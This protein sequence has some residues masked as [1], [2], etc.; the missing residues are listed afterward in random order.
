MMTMQ[1]AC[2]LPIPE[3]YQQTPNIYRLA[4][5][6]NSTGNAAKIM[7]TLAIAASTSAEKGGGKE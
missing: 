3:E 5:I 7:R 6:I 4:Q 2:A 1:E